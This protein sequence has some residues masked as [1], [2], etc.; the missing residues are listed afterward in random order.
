MLDCG[1]QDYWAYFAQNGFQPYFPT[2]RIDERRQRHHRLGLCRGRRGGGLRPHQAIET[3]E[4]KTA[5]ERWFK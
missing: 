5:F 3:K 1:G 2:F 4:Y